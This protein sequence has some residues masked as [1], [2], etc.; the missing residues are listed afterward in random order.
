MKTYED[1]ANLLETEG[2][3]ALKSRGGIRGADYF[4]FLNEDIKNP[5]GLNEEEMKSRQA[6]LEAFLQRNREFKTFIPT[7]CLKAFVRNLLAGEIPANAYKGVSYNPNLLRDG[8]KFDNLDFYAWAARLQKKF[9]GFDLTILDA[10]PYQVLNEMGESDWP[11]DLSDEEFPFWFYENMARGIESSGTLGA[12][13]ELRSRYLQAML[14]AS[15]VKGKVVSALDLIK[16]GDPILLESMKEARKTCGV[17]VLNNRLA[18]D[19]PVFYKRNGTEFAKSYTPAVV[20]EALYFLRA[21]GIKAKLG[22]TSE[23]EFDNLISKAIGAKCPD[24]NFFWFTRPFEKTA[25]REGRIYFND[26][27]D[28]VMAKLQNPDYSRWV[29]D[30]S[31][32]FS[33][34]KSVFDRVV[35]IGQRVMALLK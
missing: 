31:S 10:S 7:L 12:N 4:K 17:R 33:V 5:L 34:E 15:G 23:V 11:S 2:Q 21:N 28:S 29:G 30:V 9:R 35:D 20:A 22:P 24:Y 1:I 18:V 19:R 3:P 14:E 25:T 32:D 16:S 13:C 27:P 6:D 26:S 8:E